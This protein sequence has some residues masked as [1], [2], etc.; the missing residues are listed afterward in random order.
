[1]PIGRVARRRAAASRVQSL[2]RSIHDR[3]PT[4]PGA[5]ATQILRSPACR[6]FR[7]S[8]REQSGSPRDRAAACSVS[9][10]TPVPVGL[11]QRSSATNARRNGSPAMFRLG[12]SAFQRLPGPGTSAISGDSELGE[13]IGRK[14]VDQHLEFEGRLD[15]GL[16]PQSGRALPRVAEPDGD[17]VALRR[18]PRPTLIDSVLTQGRDVDA[19]D[20]AFEHGAV[21]GFDRGVVRRRG[22]LNCGLP[23]SEVPRQTIFRWPLSSIPKVPGGVGQHQRSIGP[24]DERRRTARVRRCPYV[25]E[26]KVLQALT[27]SALHGGSGK[28]GGAGSESFHK[29]PEISFTCQ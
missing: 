17:G 24:G 21:G 29:A 14:R 16:Q 23:I 13:F 22:S 7:A 20:A 27:A 9:G 10:S 8:T 25:R 28:S 15:I 11:P 4:S 5:S 18:K 3:E 2:R 1:M 26:D 12:S 6:P 19:V